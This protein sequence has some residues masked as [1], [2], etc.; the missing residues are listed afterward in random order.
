MSKKNYNIREFKRILVNN[1]W[2]YDHQTG[3]HEIWYKDGKHISVP[4]RNKNPM[5]FRRLINENELK[6]VH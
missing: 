3:D 4:L 2:V 1:G 6:E 5:L